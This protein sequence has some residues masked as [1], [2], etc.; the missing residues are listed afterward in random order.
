M[1][2]ITGNT[3]LTQEQKELLHSF[4]RSPLSSIF[5]L[6]GGTALSAFYLQH[7][8]SEDLDFFTNLEIEIENIL[9]FLKSLSGIKEVTYERKYDRKIFLLEYNSGVFL[10]I[11]FTKY[12]FERLAPVQKLGG[13]LVDS[14]EDILA[15]KL[16]AMTDRRDPKDYVD[17]Y[18]IMQV[19]PA[20]GIDEVM[21]QAEKKFGIKGISSI[22]SG[23]FLEPPECTGIPLLKDIKP[24]DVKCFF[25]KTARALVR[26]SIGE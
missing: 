2:E 6:S 18:A 20:M 5:Y 8:F 22:L 1:D 21:G 15:N 25:Q 9:T 10:K 3:I 12:P 19:Y 11:E 17:V 24:S 26:R 4:A 23:R 16:M 7:R 13:L 14:I